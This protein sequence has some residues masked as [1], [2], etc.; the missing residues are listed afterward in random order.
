MPCVWVQ[1][2]GMN[3]LTEKFELS[4]FRKE[5]KLQLITNKFFSI[6]FP[7]CCY[8][9]LRAIFVR[10]RQICHIVNSD[11]FKYPSFLHI[12]FLLWSIWIPEKFLKLWWL[13]PKLRLN[14]FCKY[15]QQKL[16]FGQKS[17]FDSNYIQKPT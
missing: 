2:V 13:I 7:V 6:V 4:H 1:S 8:S 17:N 16:N 14:K 5:I 3:Y 12:L 15:F 10:I 11:G 9:S